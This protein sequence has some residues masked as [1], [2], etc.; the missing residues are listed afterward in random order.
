MAKLCR[1]LLPSDI[2][3]LY[4]ADLHKQVEKFAFDEAAFFAAFSR[5]SW[6]MAVLGGFCS[7]SLNHVSM[8]ENMRGGVLLKNCSTYMITP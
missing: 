8:M 7:A 5:V 2:G 4:D 1:Y 6:Q 3:L